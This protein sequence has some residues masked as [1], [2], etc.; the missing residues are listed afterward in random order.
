MSKALIF[1]G[2]GF[3]GRAVANAFKDV[4]VNSYLADIRDA[5]NIIHC[6]VTDRD[7]VSDTIKQTNPDYIVHLAG[8]VSPQQASANPH[9]TVDINVGGTQS[10]LM[11]A[12]QKSPS[13]KITVVT[14][15]LPPT[16]AYSISKYCAE[17]IANS[18]SHAL[19]VKVA[20]MSNVYGPGDSTSTRIIPKFIRQIKSGESLTVSKTN[21]EFVYIDDAADALVLITRLGLRGKTYE[22]GGEM[23]YLP[24]L[25]AKLS[26]LCG[27]CEIDTI[28]CA[29]VP[30]KSMNSQLVFWLGW[31]PKVNLSE[32]LARTI[33]WHESNA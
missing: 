18:W 4:G 29:E 5:E 11:A 15:Y 28:S 33:K 21:R 23:I 19:H 14:S 13:A 3:I 22:V 20:R 26:N 12:L 27:D 30:P 31:N 7:S 17:V 25:A 8:V 2:A 1:G 24:D 6:D 10:V 16:E 9:S 32:G